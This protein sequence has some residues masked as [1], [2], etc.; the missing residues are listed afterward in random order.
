MRKCT[1]FKQDSSPY[2]K[3]HQ[4]SGSGKMH[5]LFEQKSSN[6]CVK[7]KFDEAHEVFS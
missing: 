5:V 2:V 6:P 1:L 7:Q 3:M 4:I